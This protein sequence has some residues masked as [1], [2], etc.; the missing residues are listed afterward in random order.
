MRRL[1]RTPALRNMMFKVRVH[2]SD[3]VQPIFVDENVE[4][5]VPISSMPGYYRLP[6]EKV[7]DEVIQVLEADVKAVILFGIPASKDATGSQAF[8]ENGVVQ[9]TVKLIKDEFGD[10]VVVI[11]DIC[12]CEYTSHGHCGLLNNGDVDNDSTLEV[13]GKIAVSHAQAGADIVAP[14]GMMDGQVKHIREAL[15]NSGFKNVAIMAY[16]A[17]YASCFYGPFREA[18]ESA[19][20]FGDRRKYQMAFGNPHEALREMELDIMEG[21][22]IIMVKPALAYLDIIR[23]ARSRFNVPIAAYNVSGEYAMIKAASQMGW[24]D[25]KAAAFEILTAIKRAGADIIITYFAKEV[26][27]WL[28]QI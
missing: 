23:L 10:D 19:P 22:D 4:K 6:V 18:A 3:L 20:Q 9:R 12:L 11:T 1:R 8:A 26:K 2:P 17:K 25:E 24:I 7:S 27:S 14:S 15:D 21:A 13:L 5:P 28:N 16:S